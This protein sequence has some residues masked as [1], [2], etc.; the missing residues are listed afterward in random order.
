MCS[1]QNFNG[2]GL[3]K[4]PIGY[5]TI[6]VALV[7]AIQFG[8]AEDNKSPLSRTTLT[9]KDCYAFALKRSENIGIA[10]E[11]IKT[12]DAKY[13]GA[14]RALF[15]EFTL[16]VSERFRNSPNQGAQVTGSNTLGGFVGTRTDRFEAG[17]KVTQPIFAGFRDFILARAIKAEELA[18]QFQKKREEEILYRD[19]S[20]SYFQVVMYERDLKEVDATIKALLDR[21]KELREWEKLGKS[22]ASEALA[23]E[24]AL[25]DARVIE[26]RVLGLIAASKEALAFLIGQRDFI[27]SH[28]LDFGT[29][30]LETLETYLDKA[31]NRSD[32]KSTANLALSAEK[33]SQATTREYLPTISMEGNSY[34]DQSPDSNRDWDV[35][36]NLKMPIFDS[37]RIQSRIAEK[38]SQ[39]RS[40]KLKVSQQQRMVDREVR[41]AFISAQTKRNELSEIK[42]FVA[43]TEKSYE[44]QRR[45]YKEGI[46]NNLDVL[47]ALQ[48][49]RQARRRLIEA[50]MQAALA[51]VGL[52]VATGDVTS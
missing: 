3:I 23:A 19:V 28:D 24:A 27:L 21:V 2:D 42:T 44:A 34:L 29:K 7:G 18:T 49:Y 8:F 10:E 16:N 22:K 47:Q 26:Q 17:I 15:P 43:A 35:I 12:A 30:K 40:A 5:F 4:L 38:E 45:D 39:F 31:S 13:Q 32:L 33:V 48:D 9:L 51:D 52:Q 1:L 36:F 37:G 20:S 25:A 46:V 14:L 41:E 11:A 50:E 6:L